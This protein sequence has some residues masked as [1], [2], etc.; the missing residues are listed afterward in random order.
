M[1]GFG[2]E[3]GK[4]RWGGWKGGVGFGCGF[5]VCGTR[6]VGVRLGCGCVVVFGVL[7]VGFWDGIHVWRERMRVTKCCQ[8]IR[9]YFLGCCCCWLPR[10]MTHIDVPHIPCYAIFPADHNAMHV[11]SPHVWIVRYQRS[12]FLN[13]TPSLRFHH[14]TTA[15]PGLQ[16]TICPD[17]MIRSTVSLCSSLARCRLGNGLSIVV[18]SC[19][20]CVHSSSKVLRTFWPLS[21]FSTV[22]R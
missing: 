7:V 14:I 19:A 8:S 13:S 5:R 9:S 6:V 17:R 12:L 20:I 1:W 4:G 18:C 21:H 3:K 11:Q 16:C 10:F 2:G 22:H 15:C